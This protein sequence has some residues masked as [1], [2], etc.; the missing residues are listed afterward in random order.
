MSVSTH[1]YDMSA[2]AYLDESVRAGPRVRCALSCELNRALEDGLRALSVHNVD[3]TELACLRR[4]DSRALERDK[5]VCAHVGHLGAEERGERA[6]PRRAEV[7]FV[8]AHPCVSLGTIDHHAV[9]ARE[10]KPEAARE[11]VAVYSRDDWN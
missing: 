4:R 6:R 9:V 3:E 8:H 10:R 1:R 5:P 7:D 11:A 2:H